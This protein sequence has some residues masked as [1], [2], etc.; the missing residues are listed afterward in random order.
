[1]VRGRGKC[2]V[3]RSDGHNQQHVAAATAAN[4]GEVFSPHTPE[5]KMTMSKMKWKQMLAGVFVACG[6]GG[7]AIGIAWATTPLGFSSALIA[8]PVA[9]DELDI[10]V[11]TDTHE[12]ELKT[13]GDWETRVVHIGIA[14]GGHSGWHTHPGP[15]FVMVTAGTVTLYDA[16][17]PTTGVDYDAGEGFVDPG[18][19]HV[20]I[21]RNNDEDTAVELVAMFL[22]PLGDSPRI[23]A[24]APTGG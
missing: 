1:V 3:R 10:K 12:L 21:A 23:D 22:I 2:A 8:G 14:P 11:E 6:F 4:R 20:H 16:D 19:G 13:K 9:L 24:P 7:I 18:G 15:V 17:D 5:R